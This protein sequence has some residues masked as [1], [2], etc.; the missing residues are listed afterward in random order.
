[1]RR[2]AAS[3]AVAAAL[4]LPSTASASFRQ[5]YSGPVGTGANN[6]GVEFHAKFRSKSAF[7]KGKPPR[8]VVDFG[9]FNVPIPGGCFDSSDAPSGFDMSVNARGKFHSTF[10]VPDTN[11]HKA[12][13]RGRFRHHNRKAVGT[14]RIKGASFSGGCVNADTGSLRWVARHGAGE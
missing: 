7:R 11:N 5:F 3:I 10:S 1:M 2:A 9:W 12:I 6:A 13:I 4:A 14:L 8:K